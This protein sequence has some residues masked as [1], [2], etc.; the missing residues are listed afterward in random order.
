MY[1]CLMS[2]TLLS[3]WINKK[4]CS[5][6]PIDNIDKSAFQ[7]I[8]MYFSS[9]I[10]FNP[11]CDVNLLKLLYSFFFISQHLN[12]IIK[13]LCVQWWVLLIKEKYKS[14]FFA[15]QMSRNKW[16]QTKH[17]RDKW[18]KK[19]MSASLFFPFKGPSRIYILHALFRIKIKLATNTK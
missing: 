8:Y 19:D 15:M 5:Y 12:F 1:L 7:S 13:S 10:I 18:K 3:R 11:K 17:T 4:F 6:F 2:R 9:W 14:S 16:C